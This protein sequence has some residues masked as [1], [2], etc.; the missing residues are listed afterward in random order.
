MVARAYLRK[1]W[2]RNAKYRNAKY[3][4]IS[5]KKKGRKLFLSRAS[6]A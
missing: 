1:Y 3:K 5:Q 2:A 6:I 4:K